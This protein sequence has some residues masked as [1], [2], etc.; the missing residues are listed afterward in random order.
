[1]FTKRLPASIAQNI[2]LPTIAAPMFLVSGPEL[3]LAACQN[4]VIGSFPTPNARTIDILDEWMEGL[5]TKLTARK[6]SEPDRRIA[7]WA[8]NI[9]AHQSYKRL[10]QDLD[11]I[12][13]YRAP[14]V[15]TAL[16][17]PAAVVEVVHS[18]GGLVFADVN[19]VKYAKKAAQTGVDGLVLV[20][21]GAGGHTGAMTGFAF[22]EA[23]RQF[24]DGMIVLGGG[25]STG[26]G[27]LAAQALGADLAYMGTKFIATTESM[28]SEEYRSMVVSATAEDLICTNA[29]TGVNA[30]MLIPSIERAGLD[31]ASLKPKGTIDFDD[32]QSNK[33]AWKEIWSAG[34]GVG[35]VQRI[36]PVEALVSELSQEYEEAR[37]EMSQLLL[38]DTVNTR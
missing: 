20:S 17:S 7:P 34:Q 19:S 3:V 14:I 5:T 36:Q 35:T 37:K 4:G 18:Y 30:N 33:K 26:R 23:V 2:S 10:Q 9:V 1:M 38:N 12:V 21:A 15:I 28:A 22:V 29:F 16:G 6:A 8:A 11:L 25:I 27:I 32:P 24:W 31:V 13:K